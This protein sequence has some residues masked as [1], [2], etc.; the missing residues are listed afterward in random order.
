MNELKKEIFYSDSV[1]E[2]MGHPPRWIVRLGT[3]VIFI[4]FMLFIFFSWLIRY[5]DIIPSTVEITTS[6]PP[7]TLVSKITGRIMLMNVSDR[8]NVKKGQLVAVME[9]TADVEEMKLLKEYMD[10]V[11]KMPDVLPDFSHL[12]ELQEYY[13]AYR[14]NHTDFIHYNSNDFYGNKIASVNQEIRGIREYIARLAVKEKMYTENQKIEQGKYYRDSLLFAGNVISVSQLE[15][16]HQALLKNSIELQQARLD[17]ADKLIELSVKQKLIQEYSINRIEEKERLLSV[18]EESFL[19][20]KA[21]LNIWQN[22]YFL[23]SPVDG[24]ATFT[25]FWSINQSVMKDEPVMSIIPTDAGEYVGRMNLKMQRSGK[26]VQGKMVNIKL[27]GYP[28]LE[29]GMVRGIVKSK[30]MVPSGDA[31]I[32]EIELPDGLTTLYNTKL[33]FTQNMQGIAEI[34]TDDTRLLQ[35]ILNPF[36][37]LISG[38]KR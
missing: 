7:V 18:M 14:K 16:S 5:P 32:I 25:K 28:Y 29:Y 30:S 20:L 24:V 6:N 8:E 19:N 21:Q 36:R 1:R 34:I 2:I 35:K 23:I 11:N 12:G 31:Y 37:H 22:N 17:H 38:N 33:E 9:T 15:I 3:V 27:S 4:L 10:T 13:A 26:V